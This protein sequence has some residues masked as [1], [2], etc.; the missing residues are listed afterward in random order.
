MTALGRV[1]SLRR[2]PVKSM[3]G[4]ELEEA[5]VGFSGVYGDR[6]YAF[7]SAAAEAVFPYF[8]GR[9]QARMLLFTPRFRNARLAA[10][11]ANLAEAT[12][13]SPSLNACFDDPENLALDVESP[14]GELLAIEDPALPALL[15]QGLEKTHDLSLLRSERALTDC[16]PLSLISMQSVAQLGREIGQSVDHRRFRANVYVDLDGGEGF[17]ED[18][19]V[20][21]SLRIGPSVEIAIVARDPRCKMITL[22]PETGEMDPKIL[23]KVGRGHGGRAGVYAA[24]LS[25]GLVS[26][27]DRIEVL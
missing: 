21:R 5:F 23:Q 25:E 24:V 4:E 12:A 11:P 19:L 10:K 22:D 13:G 7:K 9:E 2:Y 8:T 26:R 1:K 17:A 14:T 20:G 16:R 3:R 6:L 27:G 18:A 15:S